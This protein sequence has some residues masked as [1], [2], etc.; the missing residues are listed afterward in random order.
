MDRRI[1]GLVGVGFLVALLVA[2]LASGFA[3]SEPDG[4]ERVAIDEGFADAAEEH[5]LAAS[6][7][8]DYQ[9]D[10]LGDDRLGTG[11][12]G[13]VGTVIAS[14]GVVALL[15]VVWAISRRRRTPE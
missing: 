10:G 7:L 4:L 1:L 5:D 8:A 14:A 9:I 15:S 12:A 3:S 13:I 11:L 2:G 6:P